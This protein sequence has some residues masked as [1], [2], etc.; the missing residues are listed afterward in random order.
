MGYGTNSMYVLLL[1]QSQVNHSHRD[2]I[3]MVDVAFKPW[4]KLLLSKPVSGKIT[5]NVDAKSLLHPVEVHANHLG[6]HFQAFQ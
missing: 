1:S 2:L 3:S 5:P 6:Q 4:F